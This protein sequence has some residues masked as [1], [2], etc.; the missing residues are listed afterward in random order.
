M[1]QVVKIDDVVIRSF[2]EYRELVLFMI[3]E[4]INTQLIGTNKEIFTVN[5]YLIAKDDNQFT[6]EQNIKL[7]K[8]AWDSLKCHF[9][10]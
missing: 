10:Y 2:E 6:H 9:E 4:I 1:Y 5:H 8:D 3:S 7:N